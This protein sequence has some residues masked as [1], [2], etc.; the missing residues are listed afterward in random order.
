MMRISD[1]LSVRQSNLEAKAKAEAVKNE[2]IMFA[3]VKREVGRPA[4]ARKQLYIASLG[5]LSVYQKAALVHAFPAAVNADRK[6]MDEVGKE[7]KAE[8]AKQ[9]GLPGR[10]WYWLA[11]VDGMDPAK[12]KELGTAAKEI[13]LNAVLYLNAATAQMLEQMT[14]P[15]DGDV[16][17]GRT[18]IIHDAEAEVE[19]DA[20]ELAIG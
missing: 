17:T 7:T 16:A 2:P 5:H 8:L 10:E 20:E 4:V 18:V 9:T 1:L 15:D 13:A 11:N 12:A 14:A 19:V 3:I 6:Q